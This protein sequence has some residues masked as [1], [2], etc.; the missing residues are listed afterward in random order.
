MNK[1]QEMCN[2]FTKSCNN[3]FSYRDEC[4]GFL[5]NLINGFIEYCEIPK[6]QIKCIPLNQELKENWQ[7]TVLGSMHLD[8]DT[9]WHIGLI[10]TLYRAPN[11]FPHQ[12]VKMIFKVKKNQDCFLLRFGEVED[13]FEIRNPEGDLPKYYDFVVRS[14]KSHFEEGLQRFLENSAT[15]KKIGF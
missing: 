3:F 7:Y 14:I 13:V 12:P 2:S 10:L 9:Y 6:E 11:T 1:F 15:I 4:M 8:D 5:T